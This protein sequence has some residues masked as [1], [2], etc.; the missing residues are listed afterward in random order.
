MIVWLLAQLACGGGEATKSPDPAVP[1]VAAAPA[2]PPATE[3]SPATAGPPATDGRWSARSIAG[4]D[5][6]LPTHHAATPRPLAATPE[7]ERTLAHLTDAVQQHGLDPGQPWA[8]GH[9]LIALGPD[10]RVP[11]GR[12]AVDAMFEGWARPLPVEGGPTLLQ[13]PPEAQVDGHT[14]RVEPHADLVLK[15]V[16]ELGIDPAHQV[17][18]DGQP[19]AVV[20]LWRGSLLRSYLVPA[21]NHSRYASPDDVPWSLQGLSTWAPADLQWTALDGTEMTLSGLADFG[22]AVLHQETRFLAQAQA[23]GQPFQRRGQGVFRYTCGG[24]HLLQGVAFAVARGFGGERGR[25]VIEEQVGLMFYRY[26]IELDIYGQA[27]GAM[28]EHE[29]KLTIQKLKFS[30]HFLESM[31]KLAAMGFYTPDDRQQA[32]LQQA[33]A[34]V[35]ATVA[36]LDRQGAYAELGTLRTSDEQQYLDLIG[37][38]AHAV[39]GLKLALGRDEVRW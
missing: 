29:R 15:A 39:R 7:L 8:L 17:T 10:A 4:L 37:D 21:T 30:G 32:L 33:A 12:L 36:E 38:S 2:A 9:A 35:V 26:P 19:H 1:P 27:L 22:L 5:P 13:F 23:S 34:D 18:V 14:V 11:D 31:S 24:A 28:P 20:D 6:V 3:P 16:T 25:S